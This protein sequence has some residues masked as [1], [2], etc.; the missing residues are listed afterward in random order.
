MAKKAKRVKAKSAGRGQ[1]D[2]KED[3]NIPL[4]TVVD[5]VEWLEDNKHK[6]DFLAAFGKRKIKMDAATFKRVRTF[7][8]Q[9]HPDE[10][11]AAKSM[12]RGTAPACPGYRC[13]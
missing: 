8:Q 13:F 7:V 3:R 4:T 1:S 11:G 12:R 5:F 10:G 9:R 6:E 2:N